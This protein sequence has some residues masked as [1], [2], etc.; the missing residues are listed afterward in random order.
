[1]HRVKEQEKKLLP[2]N[3]DAFKTMR[4]VELVIRYYHGN[5]IGGPVDAVQLGHAG[6]MH[7]YARKPNF[8]ES[9]RETRL[10]HP[11]V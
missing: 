2:G 3:S 10:R 1:M 4:V 6:S 5:D 11:E 9:A 8:P 7:W